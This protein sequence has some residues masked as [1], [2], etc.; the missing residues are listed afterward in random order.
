MI[1]NMKV[2]KV[3]SLYQSLVYMNPWDS[4]R[5][6]LCKAPVHL[7]VTQV[8]ITLWCPFQFTHQMPPQIQRAKPVAMGQVDPVPDQDMHHSE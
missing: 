8:P 1:E 6:H 7:D 2:L 5:V 3:Y 4:L